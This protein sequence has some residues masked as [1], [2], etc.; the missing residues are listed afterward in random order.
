MGEKKDLFSLSIILYFQGKWEM[1]SK[2]QGKKVKAQ[3]EEEKRKQERTNQQEVITKLVY[4]F[5]NLQVL[6]KFLFVFSKKM[7]NDGKKNW[8]KPNE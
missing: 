7:L 4:F 2:A 8:E 3:Y 5:M 6:V 1:L